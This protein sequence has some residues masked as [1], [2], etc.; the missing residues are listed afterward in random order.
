MIPLTVISD[1]I[2]VF[3]LQ[4]VQRIRELGIV[5][6]LVGSLPKAPQQNVFLGL[7]LQLS[8]YEAIWLVHQSHAVL[9]DGLKFNKLIEQGNG[10]ARLTVSENVQYAV[11][12]NSHPYQL[13][14]PGDG[15]LSQAPVDIMSA[16][17]MPE[18]L[19]QK[20][21]ARATA[22]SFWAE[23]MAFKYLRDK[24][25]FLMPGL[26]FGGSFVAYPGDPIK[27]HSHLI[28]K[29]LQWQETIDLLKIVASGRLA[30][31]VKKSYVLVSSETEDIEDLASSQKQDATRAF[32]VEW[33]GFG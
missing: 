19:I 12:L 29:V 31:A 30:T 3:D 17:V 2:F 25:Y 6:V 15:E 5:G 9:V 11:I 13:P 4:H 1:S 27:F 18:L 10:V 32:S 23:Y 28:V 33:A 14:S 22:R 21:M 20:H 24:E 26:R 8:I 16:C 7:P